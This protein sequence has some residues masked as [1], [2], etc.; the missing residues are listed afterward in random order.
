MNFPDGHFCNYEVRIHMASPRVNDFALTRLFCAILQ[1]ANIF[2]LLRPPL[3]PK[4]AVLV[5]LRR[6]AT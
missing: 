3:H 2:T 4:Y 5:R 6:S 1:T